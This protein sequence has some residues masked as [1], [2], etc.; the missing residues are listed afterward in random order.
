MKNN[1]NIYDIDGELIR[2]AGDTHKM[3][4]AEAQE[5][6]KKYQEKIAQLSENEPNSPKIAVYNTYIKNLF[7][8][9]LKLYSEQPEIN[10]EEPAKQPDIKAQVAKAMSELKE[11]VEQ[12]DLLVERDK[13]AP[14]MDE[15][16]EPIEETDGRTA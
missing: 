15:Y 14:V 13:E 3:T 16:V 12:E 11:T 10:Q 5:Q 9:T 4:A 7:N 1:S 6:I 2:P 8:Y